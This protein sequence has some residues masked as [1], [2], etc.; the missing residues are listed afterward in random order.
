MKTLLSFGHGYSARALSRRLADEGG[1]R[2]IGTTRDE[3]GEKAIVSS[4]ADPRIWPGTDLSA[5]IESATHVLVSIAPSVDEDPVVQVC[6]D[7][8]AASEGLEWIGYL[9]STSVYGDRKGEWVDEGSK[10]SPTTQRGRLR[11]EAERSWRRLADRHGLPLHLFRLAGIYGPDRGPLHLFLAGK[12]NWVVK[13]DQYFNRIHV[14]DIA[15][16]LQASMQSPRPGAVYNVCD[17]C[18]AKSEDVMNFIAA[19]TGRPPVEVLAADAAELSD[20][21]KSFHAESKRVR[22]SKI[23]SQLGISL[24]YPEFRSGITSLYH[25]MS[26]GEGRHRL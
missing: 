10:L 21:A 7:Q 22:N 3:L 4:G 11:V 2:I 24:L 8:L 1:W 5:D 19:L 12:K 18:P 6:S 20:M 17:D 23:K 14:E 25:E 13:S 9:S 26:R 15:R 16:I